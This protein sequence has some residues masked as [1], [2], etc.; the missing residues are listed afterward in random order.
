MLGWVLVLRID[1]TSIEDKIIC[2]FNL[3]IN[4]LDQ[5]IIK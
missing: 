4:Y 2:K 5:F 1:I 3:Y